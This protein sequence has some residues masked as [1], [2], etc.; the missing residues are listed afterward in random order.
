VDCLFYLLL[1]EILLVL[2]TKSGT[3]LFILA[4]CCFFGAV[5]FVAK[6]ESAEN[7]QP[8]TSFSSKENIAVAS[9]ESKSSTPKDI[10]KPIDAIEQ[11]VLSMLKTARPDI[12]FTFLGES[13]MPGVYEVQV[14]N[15]PLLFVHEQGEYLFQGGLLQVK[16]SGIVDTMEARQ[17]INRSEIFAARSTEDM[18]IYKPEGESKAI[19]NVFTDVDCGYC[20]KFHQEVPELNAMGIEVRYL[21]FPRAGIPSGS[22]DKIAKAWCAED[23]QD[24]L[25]KV[26]SGRRVDVEVC[27]DNP[28][29]EQYAFGTELGVT[30][31]PAIIL[32]D[33]TLIPGYQPA[34]KFAEVLG[35][36]IN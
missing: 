31:T 1:W 9:P 30:G 11:S 18:I 8:E 34:K 35:L 32:M 23:Q 2:T 3:L 15:G 22:Y 26:K 29:A 24:A 13:P 17:A 28:V 36:T 25:T 33:G 20:R 12:Q 10:D 21:A 5:K 27:E 19:M 16:E 7:S 4:L 14:M 6:E